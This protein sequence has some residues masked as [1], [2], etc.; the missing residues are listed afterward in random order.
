MYT[1]SEKEWKAGEGYFGGSYAAVPG[2]PRQ[3]VLRAINIDDGRILWEVPQNG[4]G[5]SWGGV[6]YTAGGVIFYCDDNGAFAAVDEAGK[7]L[8]QFQTSVNW[9]ASPM[10][11][12]FDNKQ[13]IAVAAGSNVIAFG[14]P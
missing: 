9:K 5:A 10:T 7:P 2:E 4:N 1:K 12:M 8:W 3:K 11:Y 14:L 6:L 13:Y